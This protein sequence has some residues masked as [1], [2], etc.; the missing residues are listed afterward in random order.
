MPGYSI[1][2]NMTGAQTDKG[3]SYNSFTVCII[4]SDGVDVT[5]NFDIEYSYGSLTV[6]PVKISVYSESDSEVYDGTPLTKPGAFYSGTSDLIDSKEPM[7]GYRIV[8]TMTGSQTF[9]GDSYNA[10]TV[11]VLNSGGVDVTRNFDIDY[12][13]GTLTVSKF[14]VGVYS[15]SD[16]KVY[17]G[18]PLTKDGVFLID[19]Q[20]LANSLEIIPGHN[21]VYKVTG[22]QTKAGISTNNFTVTVLNADGMDVTPNFDIHSIYGTLNV[23]PIK[24]V[25]KSDDIT[26]FYSG[27]SVECQLSNCKMIGGELLS[28][29]NI[30]LVPEV[31][32]VD[33]CDITNSFRAIIT[34]ESGANVTENYDITYIYGRLKV[35]PRVI[36]VITPSASHTYNGEAFSCQ[37]YT[38]EPQDAL[39]SGH[40][41]AYISFSPYSIITN[42]GTTKNEL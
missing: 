3:S 7:V 9:V 17:D 36:K 23:T 24:I 4:N 41:I 20:V 35:L 32:S 22:T 14:Y 10:F 33:V 25:C 40:C 8:Y 21:I 42:V 1:I 12:H 26:E 27:N 5:R 39:L 18:T 13:Y 31:S 11:T 34:D 30:E 2:Y 37:V 6:L 28:G 29:H 15:E 19:T 16:S 38:I